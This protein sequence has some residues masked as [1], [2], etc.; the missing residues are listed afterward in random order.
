[1]VGDWRS[2]VTGQHSECYLVNRCNHSS[3]GQRH[4]IMGVEHDIMV[5]GQDIIG[6]E[7]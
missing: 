4:D 7:E 6:V 3:K 2:V 1:L 5:V